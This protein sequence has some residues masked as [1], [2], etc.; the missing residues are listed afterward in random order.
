MVSEPMY[1]R[2][3]YSDP[4]WEDDGS[5]SG[6]E[7]PGCLFPGRCIMPGEHFTSECAT[8]EMMEEIEQTREKEP[9]L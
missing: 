8:P 4:W 3:G 7:T 2:D 6:D 9:T 1:Y 5:D